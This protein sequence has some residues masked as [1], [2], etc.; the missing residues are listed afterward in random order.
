[1]RSLLSDFL[2][3]IP[4]L[5]FAQQKIKAAGGRIEVIHKPLIGHHPRNLPDP[6]PIVDFILKATGY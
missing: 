3:L 4:F 5:G 1:M 2:V 6:Q